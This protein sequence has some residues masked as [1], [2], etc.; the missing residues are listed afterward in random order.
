MKPSWMRAADREL[1][2]EWLTGLPEPVGVF[3]CY[4]IAGQEGAGSL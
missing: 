2:A 4:D 3:A 1:L